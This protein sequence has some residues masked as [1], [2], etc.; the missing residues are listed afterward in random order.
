MVVLTRF[1]MKDFMF[2]DFVKIFLYMLYTILR[3]SHSFS[4]SFCFMHPI[5]FCSFSPHPL[6]LTPK[7]PPIAK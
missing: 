3:I 7:V 2:N 4:S 6:P 1:M 5:S